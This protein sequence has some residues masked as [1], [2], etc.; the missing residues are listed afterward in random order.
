MRMRAVAEIH[1]QAQL[2]QGQC[3]LRELEELNNY[4]IFTVK[5]M[6][7]VTSL[8]QISLNHPTLRATH[9][10]Q[11]VLAHTQAS[12]VGIIPIPHAM[13]VSRFQNIIKTM[14]L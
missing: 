1:I 10:I 6:I 7:T 9:R 4:L 13:S 5:A 12:L 2:W 8:R 3:Q 14:V 11:R